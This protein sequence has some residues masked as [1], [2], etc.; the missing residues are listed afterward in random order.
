MGLFGGNKKTQQQ[1]Q[2]KGPDDNDHDN[3]ND[4]I[5]SLDD[6]GL[7]RAASGAGG[8]TVAG[9]NYSRTYE[10][11]DDNVN[12]VSSNNNNKPSSLSQDV[13]CGRRFWS[14][15][16]PCCCGR[17]NNNNNNSWF[18]VT[19]KATGRT[20][21]I[22]ESF[23]P[24][25]CYAFLWKLVCT[26][27]AILTLAWT[28]VGQEAYFALAYFTNW[29]LTF[30]C[31]YFCLSLLNTICA[32]RTPQPPTNAGCRI[33][34]TWF[35]YALAVHSTAGATVVYWPLLFDPENPDWNFVT[36]S[37]HGGLLILTI[38]DGMWVNR[39]PLRWQHWYGIL[40]VDV[41]YVG[42]T[43]VHGYV[44]NVGNPDEQDN[45]PQTNDDAIYAD[46]MEWNNDWKTALFYS[47]INCF[48]LSPIIYILLWCLSNG[49]CW[50]R[51][52]FVDAVD[53]QDQRPTVDDVEEGSIFAKWR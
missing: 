53:L 8:A 25:S 12:N 44:L 45:D 52:K 7:D 41:A 15:L 31:F 37:A 20:L 4:D 1:Q 49:V 47:C 29:A 24:A 27:I 2:E 34:L 3:D 14:E 10:D 18:A 43:L 39:I 21:D 13:N 50:D 23:A 28:F 42:W 17:N 16:N 35:I 46:V 38:V 22:P 33:R 26:A 36:L 48:V 30:V 11:E 9:P 5:V 19:D 6:L 51:R 40:I 32:S